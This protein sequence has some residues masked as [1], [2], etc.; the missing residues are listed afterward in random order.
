[1]VAE[2]SAETSSGRRFEVRRSGDVNG[3]AAEEARAG[4]SL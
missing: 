3:I 1:M 4:G 2:A